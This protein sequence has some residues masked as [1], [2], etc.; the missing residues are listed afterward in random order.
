LLSVESQFIALLTVACFADHL[1]FESVEALK[2]IP[3]D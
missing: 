2:S 3:A 1:F